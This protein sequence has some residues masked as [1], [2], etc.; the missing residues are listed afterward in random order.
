[1]LRQIFVN[2]PVADMDGHQREV[3]WMNMAAAPAQM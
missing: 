1:M 3:F 2:L